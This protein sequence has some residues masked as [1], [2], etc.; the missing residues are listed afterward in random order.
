[1]K[2]IELLRAYM[3]A[4]IVAVFLA[5]MW[6]VMSNYI[7]PGMS[8]I[9]GVLAGMEYLSASERLIAFDLIENSAENGIPAG[10]VWS[11][12]TGVVTGTLIIYYFG[13]KNATN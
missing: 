8:D 6:H 11:W 9:S 3:R 5:G 12:F 4:C 13:E 2:D 10:T 1:M 7:S